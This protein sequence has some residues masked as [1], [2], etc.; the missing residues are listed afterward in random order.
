MATNDKSKSKS[1][2]SAKHV[3][4]SGAVDDSASLKISRLLP[5][6]E[7]ELTAEAQA[8]GDKILAFPGKL[9]RRVSWA[10]RIQLAAERDA[11]DLIRTP[12]DDGEPP[13]DQGEIDGMVDKIE[14]LRLTQ[15]RWRS[16]QMTQQQAVAS[17]ESAATEVGEHKQEMLRFFDLRFRNNPEGQKRLSAI[18]AG[19]G[20][21]DL[22]QDVSDILVLCEQNEG[23]IAQGARDE[24]GRVARL[25]ELSPMLSRLL[26]DKV[27]S[28]EA[29]QARKL[30]DAAYT[31]VLNT[32]RRLRAAADYW[33]GGTDKLKD[34]APFPTSAGGGGHEEEEPAAERPI[35][36]PALAPSAP[37]S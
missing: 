8:L 21:A 32:E 1:K 15:S 22:V 29:Q 27:L 7:A 19:S 9:A 35:E 25:A 26:A 11:A 23:A 36:I 33:Y 5:E 2:S 10:S 4:D 14:L 3:D 6:R 28:P 37:P 34:Y 13:M 17:F 16:I 12:F 20:D 18:R 31:L 30:R 24:A